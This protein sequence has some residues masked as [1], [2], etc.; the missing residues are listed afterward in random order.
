MYKFYFDKK[1]EIFYSTK[2]FDTVLVKTYKNHIDLID[3]Y[4]Y[5]RQQGKTPKQALELAK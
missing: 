1:S 4:F 5:F 3:S 2:R